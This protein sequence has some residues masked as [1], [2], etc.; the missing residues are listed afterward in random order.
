[1]GLSNW[2][3]GGTNSLP[4][5]KSDLSVQL[6]KSFVAFTRLIASLSSSVVIIFQGTKRSF[7]A[8]ILPHTQLKGPQKHPEDCA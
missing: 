8:R 2:G 1:M 3:H 5:G 7:A 4:V 6:I